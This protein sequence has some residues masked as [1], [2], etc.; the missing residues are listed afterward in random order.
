MLKHEKEL[1]QKGYEDLAET[2]ARL[3]KE[4]DQLQTRS[5][6]NFEALSLFHA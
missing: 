6:D 5:A 3:Q 4:K 1:L 2:V